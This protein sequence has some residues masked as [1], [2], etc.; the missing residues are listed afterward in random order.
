MGL[1]VGRGAKSRMEDFPLAGTHEMWDL[2]LLH[3]LKGSSEPDED[4]QLRAFLLLSTLRHFDV[5]AS[6]PVFFIFSTEA[7]RTE[8]EPASLPMR[9]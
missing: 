4:L 6:E 5:R 7:Q 8:A 9:P 2:G 1:G 3:R